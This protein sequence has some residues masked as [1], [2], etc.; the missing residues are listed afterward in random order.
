MAISH[1]VADAWFCS[2]GVSAWRKARIFR[3]M[4]VRWL[5]S[6]ITVGCTWFRLKRWIRSCCYGTQL[7]ASNPDAYRMSNQKRWACDRVLVVVT[8]RSIN[9][10]CWKRVVPRVAAVGKVLEPFGSRRW[11]LTNIRHPA[12]AGTRNSVEKRPPGGYI[13]GREHFNWLTTQ[14]INGL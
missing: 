10:R 12:V 14:G 13:K 9:D 2:E 11:S 7:F 1:I 5:V 6:V 8:R 3:R 4:T